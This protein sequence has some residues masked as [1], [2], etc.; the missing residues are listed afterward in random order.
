VLLPATAGSEEIVAEAAA[1]RPAKLL[2][3][4]LP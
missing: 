1:G 2:H 3:V 4:T